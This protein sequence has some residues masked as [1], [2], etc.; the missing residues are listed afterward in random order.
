MDKYNDSYQQYDPSDD[1]NTVHATR[2]TIVRRAAAGVALIATLAGGAKL[3]FDSAADQ[4]PTPV[5]A[6]ITVQPGDTLSDI[7]EKVC[8]DKSVA[9]P[10]LRERTNDL[11]LANQLPTDQ[12]HAGQV[13]K[14]PADFCQTPGTK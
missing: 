3:A 6:R 1:P 9:W 7:A 12:V 8:T 11:Q 14:V 13:L 2:R 4:P 10:E 5:D